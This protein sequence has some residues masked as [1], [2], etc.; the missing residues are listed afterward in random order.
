[1]SENSA[2]IR[3]LLADDHLLF[4]EGLRS[5]LSGYPDFEVCGHVYRLKD[6]ESKVM[7]LKPDL[8]LLDINMHGENSLGF[9]EGLLKAYGIKIL[10]VTMYNQ[11]KLLQ[12][13]RKAG[14]HGYLLKDSGGE[15]IVRAVREIAVG[16][17]YFDKKVFSGSALQGEDN[18]AFVQKQKLTFREKEIVKLIKTGLTNEEI[19]A[20]LFLSVLTIKTHRKNIYFKLGVSNSV[21]LMNFVSENGL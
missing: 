19:A 4:S 7:T 14:F 8:L 15:D 16:G 6:I 20:E 10:I 5:L 17:Y 9:A 18:D 13:A 2:S 11:P 12:E 3:I 1:M 21:E